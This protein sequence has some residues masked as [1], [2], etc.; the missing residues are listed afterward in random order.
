VNDLTFNAYILIVL[1]VVLAILVVIIVGW[2]QLVP[3]WDRVYDSWGRMSQFPKHLI[4][5]V[6]MVIVVALIAF[7]AGLFAKDQAKSWLC[8]YDPETYPDCPAL[9]AASLTSTPSTPT[10]TPG[11]ESTPAPSPTATVAPQQASSS[12]SPSP[13]VS[14]TPTPT[15]TQSPSGTPIPLNPEQKARLAAQELKVKGLTRHH[16]SVMA[17]FA[18]AY[19]SAICVLLFGGAVLAI[20][21][22]FIATKGWASTNQYVKTIFVVMT[23]I[24]AFFGLWPPVFQ[25][26]KNL[27]DNKALFLEY[28]TLRNEIRSYPVTGTN[29]K[30]ERKEPNDFITYVDSELAR[31]GNVAIGFDYTKITYKGAFE[32]SRSNAPTPTP[33]PTPKPQPTKTP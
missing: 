31:L 27:S 5:T 16:A 12:P 17:F 23:V 22:F 14:P 13:S 28:Q 8:E 2:K 1:L 4:L 25:Q 11:P 3:F 33:T 19:Y 32:S 30:N 6:G 20:A 7:G 10:P 26:D 29:V 18:Q 24:I 9:M 15:A 21:M